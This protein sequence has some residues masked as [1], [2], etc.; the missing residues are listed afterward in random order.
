MCDRLWLEALVFKYYI[1]EEL[2]SPLELIKTTEIV[3]CFKVKIYK[4][5]WNFINN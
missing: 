1:A 2:Y 3:G 4:A 5:T